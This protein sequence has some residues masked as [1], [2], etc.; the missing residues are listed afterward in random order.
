ML[1]EEINEIK[2]VLGQGLDELLDYILVCYI[3]DY[4]L[5]LMLLKG[6]RDFESDNE[7]EVYISLN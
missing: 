5:S 1:Y 7:G 3:C 4:D 6:F 2:R